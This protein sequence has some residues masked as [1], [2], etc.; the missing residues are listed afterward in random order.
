MIIELRARI[1]SAPVSNLTRLTELKRTKQ[2]IKQGE[3]Q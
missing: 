1:D 2:K 3:N